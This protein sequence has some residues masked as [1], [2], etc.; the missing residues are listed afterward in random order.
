MFIGDGIGMTYGLSSFSLIFW[1]LMSTFS[2]IFM[3]NVFKSVFVKSSS[4]AVTASDCTSSMLSD[5]CF[6]SSAGLALMLVIG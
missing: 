3:R 5:K 4:L 2:N 1:K 6:A